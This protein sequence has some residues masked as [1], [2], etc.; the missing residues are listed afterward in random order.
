MVSYVSDSSV[1]KY[2]TIL[3]QKNKKS[4]R[5]NFSMFLQVPIGKLFMIDS[6]VHLL[7]FVISL[8]G[9]EH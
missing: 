5:S 9:S 1:S 3:S 7:D 2:I 8:D 6:V 4:H